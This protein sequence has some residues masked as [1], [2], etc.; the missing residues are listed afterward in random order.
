MG[1]KDSPDYLDDHLITG[2]CQRTVVP[3]FRVC[4]CVC[5]CVQ[6]FCSEVM[7]CWM[8][9]ANEERR[10]GAG[11]Y[12]HEAFVPSEHKKVSPYTTPC[13]E[14]CWEIHG[15]KWH[16]GLQPFNS[17]REHHGL[18]PC[19]R[20]CFSK[21]A[22]PMTKQLSPVCLWFILYLYL[23][24]GYLFCVQSWERTRSIRRWI[25]L[26]IFKQH[27]NNLSILKVHIFFFFTRESIE[28]LG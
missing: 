12:I 11:W 4:V 25:C 3:A 20:S 27:Q 15:P 9:G 18:V 1:C 21:P 17:L 5:V 7:L 10:E 26:Y 13:R 28:Y 2:S 24:L 8:S 23:C 16:K 6:S 19:S 22:S 14:T